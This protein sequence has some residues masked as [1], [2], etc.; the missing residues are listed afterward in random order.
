MFWTTIMAASE[1]YSRKPTFPI[2]NWDII[3]SGGAIPSD[4]AEPSDS[5][6]RS[7]SSDLSEVWHDVPHNGWPIV[8]CVA[9]ESRIHFQ[10]TRCNIVHLSGSYQRDNGGSDLFPLPCLHAVEWRRPPEW[11]FPREIK[12]NA[13]CRINCLHQITTT[14]ILLLFVLLSYVKHNLNLNCIVYMYTYCIH[15]YLYSCNHHMTYMSQ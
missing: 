6:N 15:V 9:C 4:P 11:Y 14:T 13:D 12:T 7:E 1:F 3:F 2:R 10:L 5:P 8:R